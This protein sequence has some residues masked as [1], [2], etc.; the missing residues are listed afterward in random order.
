MRKELLEHNPG[1]PDY[2]VS[3]IIILADKNQDGYITYPEF[4]KL[5]KE[6]ISYL[7]ILLY[8]YLKSDIYTYT[9]L[10]TEWFSS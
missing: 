2:A 1:V 3:R 5:V 8:R 4:L 7:V 9:P 6:N 10:L